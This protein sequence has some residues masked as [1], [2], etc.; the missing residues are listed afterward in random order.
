VKN[1]RRL[2]SEL[3]QQK[4]WLLHHDNASSNTSFF[5]R[6]FFLPK[7]T[8]LSPLTHPPYFSLFPQLKIKLNGR[9]FYV[10][11]VIEAESQAALNTL[12]EHNFQDALKKM[13]ETLGTVHTCRRE[14]FRG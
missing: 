3:W 13:A 9:H 5:T 1:V 11:E 12:T 7:T 2:L 14:L 4:N 6:D 10:I 8:W